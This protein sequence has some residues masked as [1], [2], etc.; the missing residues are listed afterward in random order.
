MFFF[1]QIFAVAASRYA[2]PKYKSYVSKVPG[3]CPKEMR[4]L[5]SILCEL[6]TLIF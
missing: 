2:L 4:D 1:H 3:D 6:M 5:S